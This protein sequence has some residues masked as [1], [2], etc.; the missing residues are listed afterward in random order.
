MSSYTP[1]P[2]RGSPYFVSI[3]AC[4]YVSEVFLRGFS[5]HVIN[6]LLCYGLCSSTDPSSVFSA[7]LRE[8]LSYN[9]STQGASCLAAA[10][11]VKGLLHLV[12]LTLLLTLNADPETALLDA[13]LFAAIVCA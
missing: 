11:L 4:A 9:F 8:M 7:S 13:P 5:R 2:C 1:C 3:S 12:Q 6:G 10:V